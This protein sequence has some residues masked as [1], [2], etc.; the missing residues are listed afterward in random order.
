M[1][2]ALPGFDTHVGMSMRP[3]LSCAR[4]MLESLSVMRMRGA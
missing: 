4:V 1:P 2:E 3:G